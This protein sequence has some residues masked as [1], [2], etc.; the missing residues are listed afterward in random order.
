M[1]SITTALYGGTI[2]RGSVKDEPDSN[3]TMAY[4]LAW[5][6]LTLAW[7]GSRELQIQA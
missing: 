5:L 1:N 3:E 2:W 4:Y 6:I 7:I